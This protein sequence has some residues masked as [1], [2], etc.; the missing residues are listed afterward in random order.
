MIFCTPSTC[1]TY[2]HPQRSPRSS[3]REAPRMSIVVW[4]AI[5]SCD[6]SCCFLLQ[7]VGARRQGYYASLI[8]HLSK[9][10]TFL[11]LLHCTLALSNGSLKVDFWSPYT[12]LHLV[13]FSDLGHC[14]VS[15]IS[16]G[17]WWWRAS[18]KWEDAYLS[19]LG[20]RKRQKRSGTRHVL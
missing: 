13:S 7:V 2:R 12:V 3:V 8:Q 4:E 5:G 16:I 15:S 9:E 11:Q 20:I 18:G 10:T 14:F 6:S 19:M 17:L 1:N